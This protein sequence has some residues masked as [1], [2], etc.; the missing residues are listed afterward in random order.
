MDNLTKGLDLEFL[1]ALAAHVVYGLMILF[2]IVIG[3]EFAENVKD[4]AQ[5]FSAL[6]DIQYAGGGEFVV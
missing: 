3:I 1:Y 6:R 4:A 2:A 5:A